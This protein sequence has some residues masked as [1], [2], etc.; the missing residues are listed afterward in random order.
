MTRQLLFLTTVFAAAGVAASPTFDVA[1]V[2]IGKAPDAAV[3]I[4]GGMMDTA[5]GRFRVPGIGG[6]VSLMNWT[7]GMCITAAWDLG[8]GQMSG[9]AWLNGERYDI[10]AKTSPLAT[11]AEL[12]LM[13]QSLLAERFRLVT[14]RETRE[15]AA[16]ALVVVKNASQKYLK[17]ETTGRL[18]DDLVIET[19]TREDDRWRLS[20]SCLAAC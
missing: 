4:S 20:R 17:F 16:Y 19:R 2:K 1:S 10:A 6:N 11:Q 7:L 13:L 14:H 8:P 18:S 3:L 9:P 15:M 5:N 12:R